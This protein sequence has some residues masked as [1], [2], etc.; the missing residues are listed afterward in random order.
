MPPLLPQ[1]SLQPCVSG[2]RNCRE[3]TVTT[4]SVKTNNVYLPAVSLARA[5]SKLGF[6]S[7]T[8]AESI[9]AGG[10]VTVNGVPAHNAA[11]R[12][13]MEKDRIAVDGTEVATKKKF[14]YILLNKPTGYITTRVDERGRETI[15]DLLPKTDQFVFPVGRLDMDT[16]GALIVTNDSQLGERL[17]NPES[18]CPKSYRVEAEGR[19]TDDDRRALEHGVLINGGYTTRP[20]VLRDI[21]IRESETECTIT[22][23]EGKNRQ[24]RKMFAS[25]GHEVT[26]LHR[27]AI[28]SVSVLGIAIGKWRTLDEN[29]IHRLMK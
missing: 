20:S 5:L 19:L 16:S 25:I 24:V 22:I 17:T 21:E 14:I 13:D 28:G 4:A 15:Y 27:T 3:L 7:R 9:I 1:S 6:C 8:Q 11:E 2:D 23:T 26:A 29:E 18:L 12:V 10:R